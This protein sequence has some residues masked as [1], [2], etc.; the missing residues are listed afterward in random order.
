MRTIARTLPIA[1]AALT[2]A[3]CSSTSTTAPTEAPVVE[4]EPTQAP[5]PVE[6]PTTRP[7]PKPTPEPEFDPLHPD[8][9]DPHLAE[10]SVRMVWDETDA[11]GR[12]DLC[13]SY[14]LFGPEWAQ[15]A[16]GQDGLW[17]YFEAILLEEC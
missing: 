2:L 15:E 9:I 7:A 6:E 4:Q 8:N 16:F 12:Q 11:Q 5:E 14:E 13:F 10:L 17:P 3:A 1:A